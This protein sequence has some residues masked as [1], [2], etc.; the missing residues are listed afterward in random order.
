MPNTLFEAEL[1]HMPG[2]SQAANTAKADTH[3][4]SR[5][6]RTFHKQ[7]LD[8]GT[9]ALQ[10]DGRIAKYDSIHTMPCYIGSRAFHMH[11]GH[12]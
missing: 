3:A 12:C 11:Y 6:C 1:T 5:G 4:A 9:L 7:S 2:D 10:K 8:C